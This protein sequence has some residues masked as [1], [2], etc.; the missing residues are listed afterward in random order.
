MPRVCTICTHPERAAIDQALV[1]GES[2]PR[3]AAKYRVSEDAVTRHRAHIPA[4]LAKAHDAEQAA[5]AVD[6]MAEL[7]RSMARVN[8]LFDACDRWLRDP[9]NPEQYDV[10]PRAH[11]V[12]VTYTERDGDRLVRKKARLSYLLDQSGVDVDSAET[13]YADPR[14]LL[15]RTSA[16]LQSNLEL[17]AKLIGQLD[18]RPVV[19][20]LI[21]PEWQKLRAVIIEALMDEPSARI[22]V[23]AALRMA[24]AGQ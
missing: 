19:N 10:G 20:V 4:H 16:Q 3:I 12:V 2:A 1:G 22:K 6:I 24:D 11:D 9:E 7:K 21:T 5:E 15:L 18:D 14:M 13:K 23:A 8:L 17:I